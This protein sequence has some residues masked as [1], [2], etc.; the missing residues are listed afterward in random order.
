MAFGSAGR[1]SIRLGYGCVPFRGPYA[2]TGTESPPRKQT[3]GSTFD[4][5]VSIRLVG[6]LPQRVAGKAP[7]GLLVHRDGS[8]AAVG[9]LRQL[10]PVQDRPLE[11]SAAAV[12]RDAGEVH[13]ESPSVAVSAVR[14]ADVE[15]LQ[16]QAGARQEG[17]EGVEV[18]GEPDRS[19]PARATTA[20]ACGESP[21]SASW[22]SSSVATTASRSFSYSASS[23]MSARIS[24]TSAGVA[25]SIRNVASGWPMWSESSVA[26]ERLLT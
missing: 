2:L 25:G 18:E 14:R 16:V 19:S 7:D 24:G 22:I 5:A 21:K 15:I 20:S 4:E 26:F 3:T 11:P 9:G 12:D 8:G 23:R 1:R 13:E 10:V 17:R 6:Q